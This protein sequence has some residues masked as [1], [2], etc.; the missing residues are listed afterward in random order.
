MLGVTLQPARAA[1]HVD[2][3]RTADGTEITRPD[4]SI[5][6]FYSFVAGNRLVMIMNVNPFL[7]P[8]VTTYKFPTDVSYKF[9]ID[10]NSGVNIGADTASRE[11]GGVV[12]NPAGISEDVVI[13]VTFGPTNTPVVNASCEN[14]ATCSRVRSGL[15]VFAGLRAESFIFAPFVRNNVGSIVIELPISA[16]VE[17]QSKLLLWATTTVD[18]PAGVYTE[19]G[20][21]AL[22]SQ[23]PPFVGLNALHPNQHVAAGFVRPDV[24]ILDVTRPAAFP[25]GRALSDDVVDIAARFT[26]LP[27]DR[28]AANLE[29]QACNPGGDFFP[30]PVSPPATADDVRILG[31]FPYLGRPYTPDECATLPRG[32]ID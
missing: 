26:L 4:A 12:V 7:A 30:C 29:V 28:D 24:M 14:P 31:R 23:F 17:S 6:D 1:D 16:V 5:T 18:T 10:M 3:P 9:N 22:R 20:G 2:L 13:E 11:F 21:R 27:T 15:R 8:E 19:F 32:D 25:N